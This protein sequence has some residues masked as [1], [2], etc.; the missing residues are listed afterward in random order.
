VCNQGTAP[1]PGA[2]LTLHLS[3][4]GETSSSIPPGSWLASVPVPPLPS[5]GCHE[6][7]VES[8]YVEVAGAWYVGGI[9]D[10]NDMVSELVESNNAHIGDLVGVGAA[11]DL[12]IT[13]LVGPDV[14]VPAGETFW[15]SVTA[16]NQGT[17]P[18]APTSLLLYQSAD[19]DIDGISEP[20]PADF[21]LADVPLAFI[22][23]GDCRT[24]T[25]SVSTPIPGAGYLAASV[26]EFEF[27]EELI[28]TN[29]ERIGGSLEVTGP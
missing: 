19:L 29:N 5:G 20:G 22:A 15:V 12:V 3:S 8:T 23:A 28:E 24:E 25:K 17:I 4:D 18:A 11:P 7:T 16:C 1:S 13:T 27:V 10:E 9:V 21:L 2:Q 6:A 26:D 14:P